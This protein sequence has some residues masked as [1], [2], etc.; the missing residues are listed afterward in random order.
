MGITKTSVTV[1]LV[2]ML[3]ISFSYY[4]VV[5]ESVIE[6]AKYGPCTFICDNRRDNFACFSDCL[7]DI[8]PDGGHCVGNPAR[9][10]CI[11]K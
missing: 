6:P 10:C 9:C 5:A 1:F 4:N 2:I 11:R 3:T 7:S 8:Y